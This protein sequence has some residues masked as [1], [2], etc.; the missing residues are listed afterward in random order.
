MNARSAHV[1][2][3]G[4]GTGGHLFPGLA[5]AEQLRLINP[6]IK[7]AFA[8]GGKPW[9]REQTARAGYEYLLTPSRPWPGRSWSA[10]QFLFENALGY[11]TAMRFLRSRRVAAVVGLG[12]YAS[13]DGAG[14]HQLRHSAAAAGTK[15]PAGQSQS[16]AGAARCARLSPPLK[17]RRPSCVPDL[18]PPFA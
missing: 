12:G 15:R 17:S 11:C 4:G 5:V 16:L 2:F 7:I 1:V 18:P 14:R 9:E 6:Q 8:G 13:A 10:G 3:A